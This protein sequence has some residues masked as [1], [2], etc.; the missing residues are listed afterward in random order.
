MG[1]CLVKNGEY[2]VFKNN[3][4][5]Y[6]EYD[7]YETIG[8]VEEIR[9]G[10]VVTPDGVVL[11]EGTVEQAGSAGISRPAPGAT[12]IGPKINK[13][14]PPY[15]NPEYPYGTGWY[16]CENSEHRRSCIMVLMFFRQR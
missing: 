6:A 15:S 5:R 2:Y 8:A 1:A 13:Q 11:D 12:V 14:W 9:T 7:R 16:D 4:N 10:R 3:P